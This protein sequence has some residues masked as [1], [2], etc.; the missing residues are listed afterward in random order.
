MGEVLI[1]QYQKDDRN[2]IRKIAWDTAFIGE[3]AN[4]IFYD[5]EIL[6]D[7]LTQYFTDYEP[8]SCFVA[9]SNNR[10]I[11]YLIGAKNTTILEKVFRLRIFPRL[12][13]KLMINGALFKKEN[14]SLILN[15]VLSFF[16]GEFKM[17]NLSKA[18]PATLHINLERGFRGLGIGSKLMDKYLNYLIKKR[19]PGVFLA[20]MSD[21]AAEFFG[22]HGF[23]LLHKARRSYF[24]PILKKDVPVYIYGK[25]LS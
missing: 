3:P 25:K 8:E 5:K 1:R 16:R 9:E 22:K 11:G 7:F 2:F 13:F 20:T 23:S 24:R 17:P 21:R 12:L 4:Q 15:L 10:V 18:Y 19:I 6:T 14:T